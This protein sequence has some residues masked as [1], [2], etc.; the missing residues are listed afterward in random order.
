MPKVFSVMWI[1]KTI[2]TDQILKD[3]NHSGD[4]QF[5]FLAKNSA[6]LTILCLSK[7]YKS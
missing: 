5:F 3:K 1:L 4:Y 2:M 7:R 6:F